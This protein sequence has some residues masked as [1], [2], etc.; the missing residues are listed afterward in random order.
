MK[1]PVIIEPFDISKDG[2]LRLL[3]GSPALVSVRCLGLERGP[4]AFD[5]CIIITIASSTHAPDHAISS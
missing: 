4:K 1:Q 2:G 3:A 5:G